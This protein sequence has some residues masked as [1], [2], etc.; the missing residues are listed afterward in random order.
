MFFI[1]Y[2]LACGDQTAT[3]GSDV[4][5]DDSPTETDTDGGTGSVGG[6]DT[7]TDPPTD[8]D[9]GPPTDTDTGS[10][11]DTGTGPPPAFTVEI[12]DL[13]DVSAHPIGAECPDG[14]PEIYSC[15]G[16]NPQVAWTGIPAGTVTLALIFD[17]PD[18]GDYPHWAIY[19]LPP[20]IDGL[21]AA[22]SGAS[23][24]LPHD[25]PSDPVAGIEARELKNG[26]G[27]IGY[28]GS[29]PADPHVYRWRLFALNAILP[30]ITS[31]NGF[32]QFEE[33][34]DLAGDAQMDVAVACSA[35]GPG[36]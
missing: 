2:L 3:D 17:D 21:D 33:L 35:Y 18:A 23:I 1:P 27:D 22:I 36:F 11:T 24:P 29:C 26:A 28:F 19:N 13:Y 5:P 31:G 14:L 32:D 25:L 7:P 34:E 9:T 10:P 15:D 8:T 30:A 6:T 20:T 16:S 4:G 12:P